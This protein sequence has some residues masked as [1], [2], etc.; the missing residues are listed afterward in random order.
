MYQYEKSL[1]KKGIRYIAGVDEV[2]RGPLA[3][4]MVASAVIL[5][6]ERIKFMFEDDFTNNDVLDETLKIYTQI[7]DSKILSH[8]KRLYIR[9]MIVIEAITYS[10][11]EIE[12]THIDKMGISSATQ[13]VF[14]KSVTKLKKVP[15]HILTDNF[16]IKKIT[17][18]H[19]TNIVRGDNKS[20][21]IAAASIIAKVYRDELMGKMHDK[22]PEYGFV[23]NKGYG[24]KEHL[25][26]LHKH[27]HCDIHRKS[28]EPLKSLL[29]RL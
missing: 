27:G 29:K 4:P 2:G 22:Y 17:K 25:N 28:F 15:E 16:E 12:H 8:K 7:N 24:T 13:D 26:A 3:G 6:L 21:S 9:D 20:I 14:F 19:Q 18:E 23:R 10:I 1:Y 5:D 11:V